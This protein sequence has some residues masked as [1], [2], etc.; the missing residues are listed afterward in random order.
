MENTERIVVIVVAAVVLLTTLIAL[1][2]AYLSSRNVKALTQIV[3]ARGA[4]VQ[5]QDRTEA[6]FKE[7]GIANSA[8][9][10][11][12]RQVTAMAISA[13][14]L[15]NKD[16]AADFFKNLQSLGVKVLDGL[17]NVPPP[18]VDPTAAA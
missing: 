4:D 13:A 18:P 17:P 15:V 12:W 9:L 11:G 1:V 8:T 7:L 14:L 16:D 10:E 6:G 3:M 5:W 2:Q